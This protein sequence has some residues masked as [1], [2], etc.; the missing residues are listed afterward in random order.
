VPWQTSASNLHEAR[1]LLLPELGPL[2][3]AWR[4]KATQHIALIETLNPTLPDI[5]DE[6]IVLEGAA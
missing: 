4:D 5:E 3:E 6:A 2:F 1:W